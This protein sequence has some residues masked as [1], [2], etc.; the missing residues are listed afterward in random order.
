VRQLWRAVLSGAALALA[1]CTYY[2]MPDG[3]AVPAGSAPP[4]NF[5]RT[6]TAAAAAMRDQGLAISVE[7]RARGTVVGTY[8]GGTVTANVRPQPDGSVRAQFDARNV[9]DAGLLERISSSY[10]RRLGR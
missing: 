7:D 2:V 4:S 8:D 10:D 3:T 5:E 9:R 6:F 1:A